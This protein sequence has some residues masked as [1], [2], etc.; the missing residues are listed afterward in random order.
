[1][2]WSDHSL[3]EFTDQAVRIR[4]QA[5]T[6]LL[7]FSTAIL[8]GGVTC[9]VAG[10]PV[11]GISMIVMAIL[12]PLFWFGYFAVKDPDRLGSEAFVLRHRQL[13]MEQKG[14]PAPTVIESAALGQIRE[15]PLG[16][17]SEHGEDHDV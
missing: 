15:T 12:P 6:P 5:L 7:W 8:S 13:I 4:S 14:D 9:V 1:M 3:R 16:R 11:L 17:L 2:G 10:A